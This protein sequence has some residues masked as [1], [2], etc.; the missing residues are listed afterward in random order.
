MEIP[1]ENPTVTP[2]TEV[3][4]SSPTPAV[5]APVAPSEAAPTTPAQVPDPATPAVE[6]PSPTEPQ[7][8]AEP[9]LFQLPDGR[10]VTGEVLAQEWKDKFM[11]DY[12]RKSQALAQMQKTEPQGQFNQPNPQQNQVAEPWT[13]PNWV[14][15]T[16]AEVVKAAERAI[17]L[18]TERQQ[19]EQQQ[20][21]T[22][23][24]TMV[25]SQI[26]E[27]KK[28]E[29]NLSEEKLFA[30]ANKYGFTDLRTA[31][32]NMKDFKM[33]VQRTEKQVQQ[34]IANRAAIPVSG[35]PQQGGPNPGVSYREISQGNL[36][37]QDMLRR[38]TGK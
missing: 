13:D 28:I 1:L 10:R 2:G 9:E 25:S 34:N 15:Q 35:Q 19:Q 11:P 8:P 18:K 17:E 33:A 21:R 3:T 29:P 38:I 7:A 36:T 30:H 27:I 22:Q 32:Q 5:Q 23:I 14:P 24:E 37:P 31:Y 12:T 26:D 6:T 4:P 16:Y 20:V